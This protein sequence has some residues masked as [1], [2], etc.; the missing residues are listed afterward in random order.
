[1]TMG[2]YLE[3]ERKKAERIAKDVKLTKDGMKYA[4]LKFDSKNKSKIIYVVN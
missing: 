2:K 1:M 3:D 4:S